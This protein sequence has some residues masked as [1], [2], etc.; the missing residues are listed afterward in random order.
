MRKGEARLQGDVSREV[1]GLGHGETRVMQAQFIEEAA[2]ERASIY[3]IRRLNFL[4][5]LF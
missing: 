3:K 1:A 2:S 4:L 5:I